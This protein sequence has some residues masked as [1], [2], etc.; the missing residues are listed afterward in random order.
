MVEMQPLQKHQVMAVH[1]SGM[2][3]ILQSN[4]G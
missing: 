3:E 4:L 1:I 2:K